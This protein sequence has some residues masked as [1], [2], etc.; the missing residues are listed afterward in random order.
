MIRP[1]RR[2]HRVVFAALAVLLPL[3]VAAALIARRP[4]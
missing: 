4:W 1:L 3:L 2:A